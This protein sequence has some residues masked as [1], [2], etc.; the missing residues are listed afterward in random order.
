MVAWSPPPSLRWLHSVLTLLILLNKTQ[1][2]TVITTEGGTGGTNSSNKFYNNERKS[3]EC[4]GP[5]F[6]RQGA[7]LAPPVTIT[8][9]QSPDN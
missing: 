7:N 4:F 2:K 3:K 9:K 8:V 1:H 5:Q 6:D